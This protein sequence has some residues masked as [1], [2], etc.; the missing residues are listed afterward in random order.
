MI[1]VNIG[2]I[3][4]VSA[5]ILMMLAPMISVGAVLTT[6]PELNEAFLSSDGNDVVLPNKEVVTQEVLANS[7]IIEETY[8]YAE[9]QSILGYRRTGL[10]FEDMTEL[11]EFRRGA[12]ESPISS[13]DSSTPDASNFASV[14]N[15]VGLPPIGNQGSQGSCTGWAW[16]YYCLTHQ[17]AAANGFWDTTIPSHQF[18]PAFV[19]NQINDG[20]DTGSY[21]QDASLLLNDFGCATM[22]TMPYGSS[23]YITWPSEE[24]YTESMSYRTTNQEWDYLY[25]DSDLEVLKTYLAEGNTAVISILT[26]TAFYSFDSV[27]NIYTTSHASGDLGG[28][29]AVCVVGYDD[30]KA[31]TDG[32]GAFQLVN[33]WG[34][35][36]GDSGFW[37]MSYEA[38]KD[39]DLSR[40]RFYYCDVIDQPYAPSLIA[41]LRI[42]HE[43]R[44]DVLNSEFMMSLEQYGSLTYSKLFGIGAYMAD[45]SGLYQNHPFPGNHILFDLSEFSP[46]LSTFTENEFIIEIGDSVWPVS[47]VLESFSV[48]Y[49]E[50]EIEATSSQTPH[51]ILDNQPREEVSAFLTIPSIEIYSLDTYVGGTV[52]ISGIAQGESHDTTL[53]V[54]FEPGSFENAWYTNDVNPDNGDQLWGVDTYHSYSGGSSI[55]C[56]GVPSSTA[57][58][59]EHF[60]MPIW[61][62]PSGWS[63][64]SAGSNTNPWGP[65]G[66]PT[67]YKIHCSTGG[68]SDVV[69]W[70]IQGP[71]DT[72]SATELC[73]TFWM[74]Y[75]VE[76]AQADNFASVL[77]STDGSSFT[78]LKRWWAP[79]G[80]TFSFVGEQKIMLP[81]DAISSTLYFAFIFQG[82]YAGS[83]T[84]DDIDIWDIGAEY[85]ND[86]DSYVYH[87]IDVSDFD[88]VTMSFD[89]WA[90][91]EAG[92]DWFSPAYYVNSAWTTP[93]SLGSTTGWE[94]FSMSI[95]TGA[96]RIG[97]Y[98]H[99]DLSVIRQG[100][101][102][103]NVQLVGRID[104]ISQ[105][106]IY[107]DGVSQGYATGSDTWSYSWDTTQF[108]DGIHDILA[109]AVFNTNSINDTGS[110]FVDNTAPFLTSTTEM[111]QSGNNI[112]ITGYANSLGGSP[113]IALIFTSG[114]ISAYFQ[115]PLAGMMINSTTIYWMFANSTSIPDGYYEFEI[116][117]TDYVGNSHAVA[118]ALT[119]DNSGPDVSTPPDF[120]YELGT[121][122]HSI[123]WD[124]TD[125]NPDYYELY[126][127]GVLVSTGSWSSGLEYSVDD[128]TEGTYTFTIIFWDLAGNS[129]TDDV[130][131]TVYAPSSS[132]TETTSNTSTEVTDTSTDTGTGSSTPADTPET[133]MTSV[134]IMAIAVGSAVVI[135]VVVILMKRKT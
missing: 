85:E 89:Y 126:R 110:T 37:W 40:R 59:T 27:N 61:Y 73:L 131:V 34:T 42:S 100:V 45:D 26:R 88:S 56:G 51:T 90:E 14:S 39:S 5:F 135:V 65:T 92:F 102:V 1:D 8:T 19:Y 3:V 20:E 97:F 84:V 55:W 99:S 116:T 29:H 94:H 103:D 16:A 111:Y 96:T 114:A 127:D 44:G 9:P 118:M 81:D 132:T 25:T 71:L 21:H 129:V 69:E 4:I 66:S 124:C 6:S 76:N 33:S 115:D 53:D 13:V 41:S 112:T 130:E 23:D 22:N 24:A 113:L 106:E 82:D 57:V 134:I 35:G 128:L 60:I 7:E 32:P 62:W 93:Y 17:V 120:Q 80:E 70:A 75:E 64:Y 38:I 48:H 95:P 31:T 50:W 15:L 108:L 11:E 12:K 83:M 119:V 10:L 2:K 77:Y 133:P 49:T 104:S 123:I 43:K 79:V 18:S 72:A 86:A 30:S 91:I 36:W 98:F 109:S 107:I 52:E 122:G 28:G 101:Y 125:L 117:T 54:G 68:L 74:D 78:Y 67:Q 47:G 46:Y 63:L 87:Y 105:V 121:T 58:Y